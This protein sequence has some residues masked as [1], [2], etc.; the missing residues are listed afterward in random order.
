MKAQPSVLF[1]FRRR[2]FVHIPSCVA[3]FWGSARPDI[4]YPQIKDPLETPGLAFQCSLGL[5][6]GGS[7]TVA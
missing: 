7:W 3:K 1:L 2:V 5:G 4:V 6:E